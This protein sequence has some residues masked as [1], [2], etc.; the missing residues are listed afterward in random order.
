MDIGD[1]LTTNVKHLNK[2]PVHNVASMHK[3]LQDKKY[4]Q[5]DDK[6]QSEV[7]LMDKDNIKIKVVIGYQSLSEQQQCSELPPLSQH[8]K[9][10][11]Q[12]FK[13]ISKQTSIKKL[14]TGKLSPLTGTYSKLPIGMLSG[15]S[16]CM[17]CKNNGIK[18]S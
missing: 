7:M 14:S 4:K 13:M 9:H 5:T 15:N 1:L 12:D 3:G 16:L 6:T 18:Q 17:T 10:N 8:A 2:S 11:S